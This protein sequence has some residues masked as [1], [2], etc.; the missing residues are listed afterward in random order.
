MEVPAL[1]SGL[2]KVKGLFTSIWD[3]VPEEIKGPIEQ[4]MTWIH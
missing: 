2:E 3:K 1:T 4:A